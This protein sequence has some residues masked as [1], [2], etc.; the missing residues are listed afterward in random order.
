MSECSRRERKK[1]ETHQ[2]LLEA[3][4]ELF[5]ARGYDNTAVEDITEAADVAKG[6]FFNYFENKE[7][8]LG[9]IVSWQVS[10]IA[11]QVLSAEGMQT[12]AVAQ[13]KQ[14][15]VAVAERLLPDGELARLLFT[16][17]ISESTKHESVHRLGSVV[18]ELVEQGQAR[19]EIRGNMEAGLIVRLLMTCVFYNSTQWHRA[20]IK[21]SLEDRLIES[22]N[23]LMD[24][25]GGPEWR[26]E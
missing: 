8:L 25:L 13:I 3:A 10:T 26:K 20:E 9:E 2:R 15:I 14:V 16:S 1:Q 6:T 18:H 24:G 4:W 17:R 12:S 21:F 22:I 23:A 19:E 5:R 11:D 7:A